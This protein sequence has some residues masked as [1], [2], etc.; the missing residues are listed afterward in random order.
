MAREVAAN[1]YFTEAGQGEP[2]RLKYHC[3]G[4]WLES[5]TD[6]YMDCFNPSTGEVIARAPQCTSAEVENAIDAAKAAYPEWSATPVNKQ[7]FFGD[8]H[9]MGRDGF[10]FFTETKNVTQTWFPE[11][12]EA[13]G[14]VDTWDGTITSLPDDDEERSNYE[15]RGGRHAAPF[16]RHR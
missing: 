5:E 4:H 11:D 6:T 13:G 3:N 16:L 8:L 7:S 14:K 1:R 10:A 9:V 15:K 12:A 2:V